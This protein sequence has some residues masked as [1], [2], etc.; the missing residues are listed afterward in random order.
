MDATLLILIVS[1]GAAAMSVHV[2]QFSRCQVG[3][4]CEAQ[5]D[6]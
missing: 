3:K 6:R 2:P 5:L 4:D 1:S